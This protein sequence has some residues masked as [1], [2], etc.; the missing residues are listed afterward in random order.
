LASAQPGTS[1]LPRPPP[2]ISEHVNRRFGHGSAA[3]V[4]A[5]GCAAL[6]RHAP[7]GTRLEVLDQP[8]EPRLPADRPAGPRR[9][10]PRRRR[11]PD[12]LLQPLQSHVQSL[13]RPPLHPYRL[14]F[15]PLPTGSLPLR[16]AGVLSRS[17]HPPPPSRFVTSRYLR[18]APAPGLRR[19]LS[20]GAPAAAVPGS[21]RHTRSPLPPRAPAP[22]RPATAPG[23]WPP[24]ALPPHTPPAASAPSG[25]AAPFPGS[26]PAGCLWPA[27]SSAAPPS[28]PPA[29]A[30]ASPR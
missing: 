26:P 16:V 3:P 5:R 8:L 1:S 22:L 25:S 15:P 9:R 29:A 2:P 10:V 14:R 11:P 17:S 20:L 7:V 18:R 4:V 13:Q 21:R 23:P 27:P 6:R 28:P 12:R 24:A 30:T 19:P